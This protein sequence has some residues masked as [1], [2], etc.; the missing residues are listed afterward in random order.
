[1]GQEEEGQ[2]FLLVMI[3]SAL[4]EWV[5]KMLLIIYADTTYRIYRI[6]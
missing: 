4:D 2:D 1:M 3:Y 6:L 5:Y